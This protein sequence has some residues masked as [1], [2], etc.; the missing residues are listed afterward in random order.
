MENTNDLEIKVN[1][2][3]GA[4]QANGYINMKVHYEIASLVNEQIR[5]AYNRGYRDAIRDGGK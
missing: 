4:I 5:S 3:L 2:F 1:D